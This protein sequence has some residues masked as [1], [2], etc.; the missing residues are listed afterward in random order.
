[1]DVTL[2]TSVISGSIVFVGMVVVA[3]INFRGVKL[4]ANNKESKESVDDMKSEIKTLRIRVG[5]LEAEVERLKTEK[6]DLKEENYRLMRDK[7]G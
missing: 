5:E 3:Y 7:H 4:L 2:I 1:M 6:A